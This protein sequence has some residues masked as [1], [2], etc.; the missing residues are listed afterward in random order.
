MNTLAPERIQRMTPRQLLDQLER[1]ARGEFMS[2]YGS[3]EY[4]CYKLD[5][6]RIRDEI[7]RRLRRNA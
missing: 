6:E 3:V 4:R 1:A 5:A 2:S 7:L